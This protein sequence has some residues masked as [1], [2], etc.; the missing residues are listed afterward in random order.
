MGNGN[1][2]AIRSE[3][4]NVNLNSQ[5][6][7][8]VVSTGLFPAHHNRAGAPEKGYQTPDSGVPDKRRAL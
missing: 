7:P 2:R 8:D 5:I 6:R 1:A 4:N 3:F